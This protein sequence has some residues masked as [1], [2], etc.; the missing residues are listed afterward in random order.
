M[1]IKIYNLEGKAKKTINLPDELFN[2][3]LNQNL[4][5]QV[6]YVY[7][8]NKRRP[9]AHTKTRAEVRGGGRKPWPQKG[10]GRARHGS[11]RSPIWRGGG[12]TFGPRKEKKYTAKINKKVKRKAIFITLSQKI[13]DKE[14]FIIEGLELK[15][16]KTKEA[17]K[18]IENIK[19]NIIKNT[20]GSPSFFFILDKEK[21][22]N[23]KKAFSNLEKVELAQVE[24]INAYKLLSKKYIITEPKTIDLIINHYNY[25]KK[26]KK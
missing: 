20:E 2:L 3:P 18:I 10:T 19:Q 16:K 7:Q 8:K 4:L 15:N 14:F 26:N 6:V 12:I 24:N 22:K 25:A 9:I 1:K 11:I 23:Y 21:F 17:V 13:R 5:H